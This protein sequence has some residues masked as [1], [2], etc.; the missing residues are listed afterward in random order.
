MTK[1]AI[2]TCPIMF[3]VC[4]QKFAQTLS[5]GKT[6]IPRRNDKQRV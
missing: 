3:L 2:C 4:P 1:F 6:A 5:A